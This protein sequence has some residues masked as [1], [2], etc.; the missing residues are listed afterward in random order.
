M[1]TVLT[2]Q[3]KAVAS[4]FGVR[5]RD[6]RWS[7]YGAVEALE[8]RLVLAT[9]TW[10]GGA[11]TSVW[12]DA[13][14]WDTDVVPTIAD[15]VVIPAG[16]S[17][18]ITLSGDAEAGTLLSERAIVVDGGRTLEIAVSAEMHADLALP[19]GT[20]RGG[21]LGFEAGALA[22]GSNPGT[23]DGVTVLDEILPGF[24]RVRLEGSTRFPAVRML[25][26]GGQ[27]LLAPGYTLHDDIII[28]GEGSRR[29][30]L[31]EGGPGVVTLSTTASLVRAP[32]STA[33]VDV[34]Q[35]DNATL[36]NE[37]LIEVNGSGR[38]SIGA[39]AAMV[40]EGTLRLGGGNLDLYAISD[41]SSPGFVEVHGGTLGLL[42]SFSTDDLGLDRWTRTGGVVEL[43]T[44]LENQS[45]TLTLNG[46]T[47][48]W[49]VVRGG[50]EGGTVAFADGAVLDYTVEG[51][52][53]IDV[54]IAG[55]ILLGGQADNVTIIGA[56]RF[57]ALRLIGANSS[58]NFGPGYVLHDNVIAEGAGVGT[59]R[60]KLA[61][62][63]AGT[64]TV[65][66]SASIILAPGCGGGLEINRD[67]TVTFI[68]HGV[69]SAEAAGQELRIPIDID[70]L[71]N[72][73]TI[74]ATAG[75]LFLGPNAWTSDGLVAA[76][77]AELLLGGD[78]SNTG[79]VVLTNT[80]LELAASATT[81]GLGLHRWTRSGGTITFTGTIDN[82]GDTLTINASTG[83]WMLADGRFEGGS[84]AFADGA[85][86]DYTPEGVWF[87]GV[88]LLGEIVLDDPGDYAFVYLDTRF[89]GARLLAGDASLRLG[90]GYTLHDPVIAEGA[91]P[92]DREIWVAYAGPGDVVFGPDATVTLAPGAGGGLEIRR[93][94]AATLVNRGSIAALASG[95][96]LS[97]VGDMPF[98]NEGTLEVGGGMMAVTPTQLT[99]VVGGVLTGG[100]WIVSD[101]V[102]TTAGG[103]IGTADAT[104][105]LRGGGS[106]AQLGALSLNLG[107]LTLAEGAQLTVASFTNAGALT[108]GPGS[109]L[110]VGGDYTQTNGAS[111]AVGIAGS[112]DPSGYGRIGA[113]GRAMLDGALSASYVDGFVP[114]EGT[115]IDFISA[116]GGRTGT[117][118]GA[119]L[120]DAPPGDRTAL[121][122]EAGRV[123]LLSTDLAD[124]T[125]DGIVDTRDLLAYLNLWSADDPTADVNGDGV[126]D[127]R[128]FL[129]FLNLFN[130]G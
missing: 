55:E 106:W 126:V 41:F 90:P 75:R 5:R 54:G 49:R 33:S 56:T 13:A 10:D 24:G 97:I 50:I 8:P 60:I 95:Q 119:D 40:N 128:D 57:T 116:A 47:G 3:Q 102:L 120:P 35:S 91:A 11:G 21:V 92:G 114:G 82:T 94:R 66:E 7:W 30:W 129:F 80:Q 39:L 4:N 100:T 79:D 53:L 45:N 27:V 70:S 51:G 43:R 87:T 127:T 108:L 69:I 105:E 12:N 83:S 93:S 125:L 38:F 59:R 28:E 117:F 81:A 65:A 44:T 78:W 109:A 107:S 130:D 22:F 6:S 34:E 58:V 37:G 113:T 101:G 15:D 19:G 85:A 46:K 98:T 84:I 9:V 16:G 77:D 123:S 62:N 99:N 25:G 88:Q 122:Y 29:I 71:T 76:T 36:I 31:A 61:Y 124:I 23:L 103:D 1:R 115:F 52:N 118:A 86:F 111:L 68:N 112:D 17:G 89:A 67:K 64:F 26:H 121:V 14:N 42:S 2:A 63:A 96:T 110:L 104:I 32:G 18:A 20:L 73:G 72:T 74:R 48:S